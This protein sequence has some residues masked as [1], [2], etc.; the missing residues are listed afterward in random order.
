MPPLQLYGP[1][2]AR[3]VINICLQRF[4]IWVTIIN[5]IKLEVNLH[6]INKYFISSP[7]LWDRP[8]VKFFKFTWKIRNQLNRKKNQILD[9]SDFYFSSY[10]HFLVI[11]WHY[12]PNFRWIFHDNSKNKNRNIL[13]FRFSF[14]SA[15]FASSIK[16]GS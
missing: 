15:H 4:S 9:F 2:L 5:T 11:L 13:L 8:L 1:G 7:K 14:Y 3:Q 16:T 12:H 6:I 10:E